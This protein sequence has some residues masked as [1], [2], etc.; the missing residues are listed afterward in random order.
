MK[1][2]G[3]YILKGYSSWHTISLVS[4]PFDTTSCIYIYIYTRWYQKV[5]RLGLYTRMYSLDSRLGTIPLGNGSAPT[6]PPPPPPTPA[7]LSLLERV[8]EVLLSQRV[9]HI[10]RF[11][12]DLLHGVK[13]STFQLLLYLRE[14]RKPDAATWATLSY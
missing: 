13:I 11:A 12:L 8:L 10:L 6:H 14:E 9:K 4:E 2:S 7:P 5:P 3:C 1:L